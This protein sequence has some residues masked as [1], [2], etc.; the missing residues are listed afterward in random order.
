LWPPRFPGRR[1]INLPDPRKAPTQGT[2]PPGF[3][4]GGDFSGQRALYCD[5]LGPPPPD[6]GALK[7]VIAHRLS[8]AAGRH[9]PQHAAAWIVVADDKNLPVS[10]GSDIAIG[11]HLS[12]RM[13]IDVPSGSTAVLPVPMSGFRIQLWTLIRGRPKPAQCQERTSC[14]VLYECY[15]NAIRLCHALFRRCRG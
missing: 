15:R 8:D 6:H 7:L 2:G 1:R 11:V 3:H 5:G 13:D 9:Q 4:P 10:A 12:S 14:A